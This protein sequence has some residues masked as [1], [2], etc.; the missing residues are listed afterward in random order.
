MFIYFI[1][2]I[3]LANDG[4]RSKSTYNEYIPRLDFLNRYRC[5]TIHTRILYSSWNIETG[6]GSFEH[7]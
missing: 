5:Q 4:N 6:I 2:I 7:D 1:F 3:E